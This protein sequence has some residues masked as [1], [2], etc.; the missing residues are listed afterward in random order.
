MA[1]NTD[2]YDSG[3][4]EALDNLS[5]QESLTMAEISAA[6]AG[7]NSC[8]SALLDLAEIRAKRQ[9][10]FNMQNEYA[11]SQQ[12]AQQQESFAKQAGLEP[13]DILKM[14][15]GSQHCQEMTM[16]EL[17]NSVTRAERGLSP[18]DP[19]YEPPTK[20]KKT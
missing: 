18:Y 6:K 15:Q 3:A 9:Q 10:L 17:A 12:P 16:A 19:E 8:G 4:Q 2:Y 7:G 1:R 20:K 14:V 13:K 11:Q 5:Y